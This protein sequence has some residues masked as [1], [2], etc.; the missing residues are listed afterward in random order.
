MRSHQLPKLLPTRAYV[1]L[2][3]PLQKD[4]Y[5]FVLSV[6]HGV[7]EGQFPTYV[8]VHAKLAYVILDKPL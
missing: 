2:D 1:I 3:K 4:V 6:E 7:S 8:L 5:R